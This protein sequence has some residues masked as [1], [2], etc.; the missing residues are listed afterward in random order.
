M[1]YEYAD[2]YDIP[3]GKV[4]AQVIA[5]VKEALDLRHGDAGDPEGPLRSV[6]WEEGHQAVMQELVRVRSRSDRVDGLLAKATQAKGRA[7]R[8]QE[9]AAFIASQA[10]DEAQVSNSNRRLPNSFT[11][12]EEKN[13]DAALD[14]LEERRAAHQAE[15][16][17]SITSESYDVINQ[18]HWQLNA[19]RTDLRA[20]IHAIQFE[21]SLER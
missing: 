18:I 7:R 21:N 3:F 4:E 19:I 8:A 17:V 5:W 12:R 15:R 11:T 16:L 1:S 14:S 13:A 9:H 20:Q 10:Y 6:P 2:A